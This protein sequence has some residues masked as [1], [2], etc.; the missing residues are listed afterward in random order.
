M[1]FHLINWYFDTFIFD[2]LN[3]DAKESLTFQLCDTHTNAHSLQNVLQP[4]WNSIKMSRKMK[5]FNWKTCNINAQ[6]DWVNRIKEW[7]VYFD[8]RLLS[9]IYKR[10]K[11][12]QM[13]IQYIEC[14]ALMSSIKSWYHKIG[15]IMFLDN[16][17]ETAWIEF[18]FLERNEK[19]ENKHCI[20]DEGF[21][22]TTIACTID[23]RCTPIV[24]VQY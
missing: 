20:F 17:I 6:L 9:F 14:W 7:V 13:C 8:W 10:W 15:A 19:T 22:T 21:S 16:I 11:Q 23:P 1:V 18:E 24:L 2:R 12:T 4:N 5:S 3:F